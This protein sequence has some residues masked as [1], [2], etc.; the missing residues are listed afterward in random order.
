MNL[1]VKLKGANGEV[2]I[3]HKCDRSWNGDF[4]V[5]LKDKTIDDAIKCYQSMAPQ[6]QEE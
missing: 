4:Y 5:T 6:A 1:T 3:S 2:E